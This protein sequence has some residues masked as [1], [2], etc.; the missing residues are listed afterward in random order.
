MLLLTL[1]LPLCAC[2]APPEQ[3]ASDAG[4]ADLRPSDLRR[5]ELALDRA[6][7]FV[8]ASAA[9]GT[10]LRVLTANVGNLDGVWKRPCP[11][12]YQGAQCELATEKVIAA[13]LAAYKP[14]IVV[15]NEVFDADLCAGKGEANPKWI[16]TG[17]KGRLPYQQVRRYLGPDYTIVCDGIAHYDC[18]G[19]LT[20]RFT[21]KQCAAGT[22]CL[23]AATTP[24]HPAACKGIGSI[25]SVS[26]A[27][28]NLAGQAITVVNGHP[29]NA[30]D[31]TGDACRHA[32]Y[33][34]IF[35]QLAIGTRNLIMGDM[36]GDPIRFP[37]V[38][39]SFSYWNTKVGKGKRFRYHSGPAEASPPPATW[40][41]FFTLDYVLSDFLQGTCRTLG[42]QADAHRLDHPIKRM[43]HLAIVCDLEFP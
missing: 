10:R 30:V 29:L 19:A 39:K 37:T 43:D 42:A 5:D 22:V 12:Y 21:V 38:F 9:K 40:E 25:T 36:N 18:I 34:Q 41:K 32:Q 11:S 23:G 13:A 26:A 27:H 28:L 8:E 15:L 35:E 24:A 14:D 3:H 16:C 6:A 7:S 33:K 2:H 1:A 31:Y 4:G 20:K 17:Y